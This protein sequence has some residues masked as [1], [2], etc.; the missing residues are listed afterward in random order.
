[1]E[2]SHRKLYKPAQ[3]A[4]VYLL[5]AEYMYIEYYSG[6]EGRLAFFF[7]FKMNWLFVVVLYISSA[8]PIFL[9]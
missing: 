3:S 6:L 4:S 5:H 9:S 1:M 7:P 2:L 8:Q